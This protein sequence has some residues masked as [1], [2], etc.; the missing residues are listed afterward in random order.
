MSKILKHRILSLRNEGKTYNEI[1]KELRCSK[2]TISYHCG[3]FNIPDN[4][5]SKERI[6]QYQKFYDSG[7]NLK[8]TSFKFNI[9]RQTL[10]KYIVQRSITKKIKRDTKNYR[11]EVKRKAVEYK[12]GAC[13]ICGYNTVLS[14]LDFHH[15]DPTIK[16]Y[17]I[18]SG[19]KSFESI[20]DELD[21]CILVCRNCHS[22]I[23]EGLHSEYIL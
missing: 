2:G 17:G 6:E 12:G 14:A 10:S 21:K 16:N 19:T 15:I 1:A 7:K 3:K 18:S 20:K 22:E 9:S 11:A 13:C 4:R 8:E 5:F 23:H